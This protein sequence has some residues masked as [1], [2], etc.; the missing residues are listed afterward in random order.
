MTDTRWTARIGADALRDGDRGGLELT[1]RRRRAAVLAT[2]L[3]YAALVG[4]FWLNGAADLPRWTAML[5]IAAGAALLAG[6]TTVFVGAW[7]DR[8]NQ[9]DAALDERE[10]AV[11]DRAYRSSYTVVGTLCVTTV[12]YAAIAADSGR[13]W[14]PSTSNEW[15]AVV[16]GVLLLVMTIPTA[17]LAWTEPDPVPD[18]PA[19]GRVANR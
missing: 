1:R 6:L 16:W 13:G 18:E 7:W 19:D 15:Q 8:A 4:S 5:P 14:L 9:V 3:G 11:R 12:V 10:R 2:Y 17:V